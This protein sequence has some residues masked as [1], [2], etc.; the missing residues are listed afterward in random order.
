MINLIH[1]ITRKKYFAIAQLF[2]CLSLLFGTWVIYIPTISN[3]LNLTEG[4]LGIVFLFGA[5]GAFIS[6]PFGKYFVSIIG[7]GKLAFI[8][9]LLYSFAVFCNFIAGSYFYLIIA[10]LFNGM[11]A[12]F[13][14]IGIN[15][16][17]SSIEKEE[18]I[19]I[20]SACHGFYSLGGII[21][22]GFGTVLL[23]A[24]KNPLKHIITIILLVILLQAYSFSN[25]IYSKKEAKSKSDPKKISISKLKSKSLW[26]LAVV[27][28]CA[29]VSEGAI[30]DWSAL[31]LNKVAM[32]RNEMAGL[33]FAGFSVSM[34][35]VRFLGD[36][37]TR[38][39]GAWKVITI[40]Y[41]IGVVGFIF[42]LIANPYVTILGFTIIGIGFS[43]IVPEVYRL[44]SNIRGV[45][46]STGIAFMAGA[47]FFGFLAGPV[48]LGAIAEVYG[49]KASFFTVLGIA[50]VGLASSLYIQY[51]YYTRFAGNK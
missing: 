37:I 18:N 14:Q 7:E 3:K 21:S 46:P 8:S 17:V 40:G 43:I 35:I 6:L 23:I 31:F 16:L 9:I 24:F 38:K 13:L 29:M 2:L 26:A 28:L 5:I 42:V 50:L 10:F 51:F 4:Q 34:T 19:A 47:G 39:F 25:Y 27:A 48:I 36:S 32:S 1:I 20:M 11:L 49:L 41:L 15:S 45:E 30:A 44:S 33:G 22:A 12:S